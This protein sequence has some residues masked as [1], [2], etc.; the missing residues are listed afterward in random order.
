MGLGE[1]GSDIYKT[2]AKWVSDSLFA[3]SIVVSPP[4]GS[5]SFPAYC[6]SALVKT[7]PSCLFTFDLHLL[8]TPKKQLATF[9]TGI[10]N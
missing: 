4:C 3:L 5:S 7:T 1:H 6:G 2:D 10:L 8:P 9:K